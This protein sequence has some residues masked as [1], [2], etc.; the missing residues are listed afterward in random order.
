MVYQPVA[1]SFHQKIMTEIAGGNAPDVFIC[2]GYGKLLEYVKRDILL[3]LT[4]YVQK[5]TEYKL[6]DQYE[7]VVETLKVDGRVYGIPSNM[8]T[9]ILYYNKDHFDEAG[10]S[11]P[12]DDW[13]W[14]NLIQAAK[15]LTIRSEKGRVE[16]YGIMVS[17]NSYNDFFMFMKQFG[18]RFLNEDKTRCVV[19]SPQNL[20]AL[21]LLDS[22]GKVHRVAPTLTAMGTE[23][24]FATTYGASGQ[25]FKKQR[26]SMIIGGRWLVINL[27]PAKELNYRF[28]LLP[29]GKVR[30]SE[31]GTAPWVAYKG[32]KNPDLVWKFLKS[33]GSREGQMLLVGLGDSLP[34]YKDLLESETF[35]KD[36]AHPNEDNSVF[37]K[38]IPYTYTDVEFTS[39]FYNWEEIASKVLI[40]QLD[41][42]ALGMQTAEETLK[43]IEDEMNRMIEEGRKGR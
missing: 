18:G 38:T 7:S 26:C 12:T 30:A 13:T 1:G 2:F 31:L 11:Y 29:R 35:L 24:G 10:I 34:T 14:D 32:T 42:L 21:K 20:E 37:V 23:M 28:A 8:G 5:D 27:R 17:P 15:K 22:F 19:N 16:R 3:D 40:P 33:L 43:T 39:P 36:S 9:N 41:E 4:D 6:D 25:M